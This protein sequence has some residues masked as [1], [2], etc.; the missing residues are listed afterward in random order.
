MWFA[1]CSV[2]DE[3][4]HSKCPNGYELRQGFRPVVIDFDVSAKRAVVTGELQSQN[5]M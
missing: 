2:V 3:T 5:E 1:N 4:T